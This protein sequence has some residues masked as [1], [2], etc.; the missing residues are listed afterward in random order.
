ML[1]EG[2][3]AGGM[4]VSMMLWSGMRVYGHTRLFLGTLGIFWEHK[5]F[6]LCNTKKCL[7]RSVCSLL[8][9]SAGV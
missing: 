6:V 4:G 5:A 3:S 7:L 1:D 9:L 8:G 2:E